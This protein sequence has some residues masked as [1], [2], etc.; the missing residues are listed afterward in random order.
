MRIVTKDE[1]GHPFRAAKIDAV[2]LDQRRRELFEVSGYC[3]IRGFCEPEETERVRRFWHGYDM[4]FGVKGYWH[5][6]ANY[7]MHL[8]GLTERYECFFWNPPEDP[9]TYELAWSAQMVRNAIAGDPVYHHLTGFESIV[10]TYRPTRTDAGDAGIVAHDDREHPTQTHR[11]QVSLA[12]S[13]VGED[14]AGGGTRLRL[15]DG[16]LVNIHERESLRAGDLLLFNQV[17]EH[18]V[19]PVTRSNPADPLSGHWRLIM[20]DHRVDRDASESSA[21]RN[22]VLVPRKILDAYER[23][24]FRDGMRLVK[25]LVRKRKQP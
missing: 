18:S 17:N 14:Y 21:Q 10:A 22:A 1:A 2:Q 20:P 25:R 8:E 15:Y 16:T 13:T 4:P 24:T 6:R 9:L 19:D 7:R 11:I 5:G 12:L 23:P 3:V